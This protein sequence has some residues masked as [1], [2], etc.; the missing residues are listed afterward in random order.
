MSEVTSIPDWMI[1]VFNAVWNIELKPPPYDITVS[2]RRESDTTLWVEMNRGILNVGEKLLE[3]LLELSSERKEVAE[4][5]TEALFCHESRHVAPDGYPYTLFNNKMTVMKVLEVLMRKVGINTEKGRR[6]GERLLLKTASFITNLLSDI[7]VDAVTKDKVGKDKLL[8]ANMFWFNS[9]RSSGNSLIFMVYGELYRRIVGVNYYPEELHEHIVKNLP[10]D[11]LDA[12]DEMEKLM[13]SAYIHS[14]ASDQKRAM[15]LI[16]KTAEKLA[17]ILVRYKEFHMPVISLGRKAEEGYWW[18]EIEIGGVIPFLPDD[19]EDYEDEMEGEL[20]QSEVGG[21]FFEA[22]DNNVPPRFVRWLTGQ[23]LDPYEKREIYERVLNAKIERKIEQYLIGFTR[24]E[25]IS[26]SIKIPSAVRWKPGMKPK[27][28]SLMRP[29]RPDLWHSRRKIEFPVPSKV[30]KDLGYDHVFIIIDTS[31]STGLDAGGERI[32]DIEKEASFM[33]LAFAKMFH[34]DV[35]VISFNDFAYLIYQGDDYVAAGRAIYSLYPSGSTYLSSVG[36]VIQ[37]SDVTNSLIFIMTDG[38]IWGGIGLIKELAMNDNE[39]VIIQV[40]G[41]LERTVLY[42]WMEE[43]GEKKD[44]NVKWFLTT[45]SKM[46]G[47]AFTL[48]SDIAASKIKAEKRK[49][50]RKRMV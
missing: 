48:L 18:N 7:I 2:K 27:P 6:R 36:S 38:D 9:G 26:S 41:G 40:T 47:L 14:S 50:K 45:P 8:A 49:R 44:V 46:K 4:R 3:D 43:S 37:A 24:D 1:N 35:T 17:D 34:S 11:V 25:E 12:I 31:D 16:V 29:N 28:K 19:I 10:K 13:K 20:T 39:V 42:N 33:A 5:I 21:L 15:N 30:E 22:L 32:L 23:D